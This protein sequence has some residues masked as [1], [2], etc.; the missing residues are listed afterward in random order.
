MLIL[1]RSTGELVL[2][3]RGKPKSTVVDR[4]EVYERIKQL[5]QCDAN[6]DEREPLP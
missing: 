4:K 2:V 6:E 3:G 5:L 1:T